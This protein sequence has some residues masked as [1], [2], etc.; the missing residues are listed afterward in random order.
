MV[1]MCIH[2]TYVAVDDAY[3]WGRDCVEVCHWAEL[4]QVTFV[5]IYKTL[6][7]TWVSYL[8]LLVV[9][10]LFCHV[11]VVSIPPPASSLDLYTIIH[12]LCWRLSAI[13]LTLCFVTFSLSHTL[14]YV[15]SEI[16][17]QS[18][19]KAPNIWSTEPDSFVSY[20]LS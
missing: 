12:L 17:I 11:L 3:M 2:S 14:S 8:L 19:H 9:F 18:N 1:C 6:K 5:F 4:Y 20:L 7:P 15:V 10:L 13:Y 16:K